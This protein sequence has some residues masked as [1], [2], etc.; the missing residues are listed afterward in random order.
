MNTLTRKELKLLVA[1]LGGADAV[2]KM[3]PNFHTD[4]GWQDAKHPNFT[5]GQE[6][7]LLNIIGVQG[8]LDV[9]N[10]KKFVLSNGSTAKKKKKPASSIDFIVRDHFKKN[11]SEVKFYEF[12]SNFEKWFM[13]EV[14]EL[15]A[16]ELPMYHHDLQHDSRDVEILTDLGGK[17][18]VEV[19][20]A[21]VFEL[22]K[23]QPHGGEFGILNS[24]ANIFY[25]RDAKGELRAVSVYWRVSGWVVCADRVG[26][27]RKWSTGYRVFSRD[28]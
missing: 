20:L 18:A 6:E 14:E 26:G 15:T 3:V 2:R 1:L 8:A 9:L 23:L 11:S 10:G 13:G 4:S 5:F 17:E 7:A 16:V 19:T 25:V 22:L 24:L 21:G 27:V 12:G 28:S